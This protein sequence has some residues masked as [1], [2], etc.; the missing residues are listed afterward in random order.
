MESLIKQFYI[1]TLFKIALIL[2]WD[3]LGCW[4]NRKME[5]WMGT[6]EKNYGI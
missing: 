5:Y 4:C 1:H 2:H 3:T 6:G